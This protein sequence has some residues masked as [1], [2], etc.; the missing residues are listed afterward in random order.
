MESLPVGMAVTLNGAAGCHGKL[1]WVWMSNGHSYTL[2]L[3]LTLSFS[4]FP[5]DLLPLSPSL[6]MTPCVALFFFIPLPHCFPILSVSYLHFISLGPHPFTPPKL[7]PFW[8]SPW[9]F[10]RGHGPCLAYVDFHF[11]KNLSHA[12]VHGETSLRS[13]LHVVSCVGE[14]DL[15]SKNTATTYKNNISPTVSAINHGQKL[16][17]F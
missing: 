2:S 15:S 16:A 1:R 6:S 8:P 12:G 4:F 10:E 5:C 3:S 11:P 14:V 9:R 7:F 13:P 17:F